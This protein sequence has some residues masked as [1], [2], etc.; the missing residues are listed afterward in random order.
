[1]KKLTAENQQLKTAAPTTAAPTPP[2]LPPKRA[3]GAAAARGHDPWSS[4]LGEDEAV[5]SAEPEAKAGA[6]V[7]TKAEAKPEAKA[8][9][10]AE[11]KGGGQGALTAAELKALAG[12]LSGS[13]PGPKAP[14]RLPP[15]PATKHP[16]SSS[17]S[18]PPPK[19]AVLTEQQLEAELGDDTYLRALVQRKDA[20][21]AKNVPS[22]PTPPS[23]G[24][25]GV[26]AHMEL[27]LYKPERSA[28]VGVQ[29][30]PAP[31]GAGVLI[32]DMNQQA[33]GFEAGLR[34]NDRLLSVD[35]QRCTDPTQTATM[36]KA[37][38]GKVRLEVVRSEVEAKRKVHPFK[39]WKRK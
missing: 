31:D 19:P 4:F 2:S 7:E 28:V 21:R 15:K 8:E 3:G 1:M 39:F 18:G 16:P 12:A 32:V 25:T 38:V 33:H 23:P 34:V 11:A 14:P 26:A 30:D 36:L 29:C 13:E 5:S 35:G 20:K 9:A 6:K 27:T 17:A 24:G 22:V 37:A 10:K